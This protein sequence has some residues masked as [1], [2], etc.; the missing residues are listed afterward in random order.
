[1]EMTRI[2]DVITVGHETHFR[3]ELWFALRV[4]TTLTILQKRVP[5][6]DMINLASFVVQSTRIAMIML[7]RPSL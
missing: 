6:N 5:V 4:E 7:T 3:L 1:M 2:Q